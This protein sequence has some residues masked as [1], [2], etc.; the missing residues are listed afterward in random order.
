MSLR[1]CQTCCQV[2]YSIVGIISIVLV[3][4]VILI[5]GQRGNEMILY[6]GLFYI[7][8]TILG[9]IAVC[10]SCKCLQC[11]IHT[12]YGILETIVTAALV[13]VVFVC[14]QA[15][16]EQCT[17][18]MPTVGGAFVLITLMWMFFGCCASSSESDNMPLYS[19]VSQPYYISE[20]IHPQPNS[21][22]QLLNNICL[23]YTSPS[24][25]DQRGSRMPSSA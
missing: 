7:A 1:G 4:Y 19:P 15:S 16:A 17:I 10:C 24:P 22:I 25:R 6:L 21:Y 9:I 13:Y 18:L 11:F 14:M 3:A 5:F 8:F 2:F 12:I 23:L 20:E